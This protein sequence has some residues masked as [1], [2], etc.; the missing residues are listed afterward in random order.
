MVE[1]AAE[2]PFIIFTCLDH[3]KLTAVDCAVVSHSHARARGLKDFP[4][5]SS[6]SSSPLFPFSLAFSQLSPVFSATPIS[7]SSGKDLN[8]LF[9]S[10]VFFLYDFIYRVFF[11][12]C[13]CF[14]CSFCF[15]VF[16][17]LA[18]VEFKTLR[19]GCSTIIILLL[20]VLSI[21][22]LLFCAF[23][24]IAVFHAE[25]SSAALVSCS[26]MCVLLWKLENALFF[27]INLNSPCV[28]VLDCEE[29]HDS[30]LWISLCLSGSLCVSLST[31]S[32][33][34]SHFGCTTARFCYLLIYR[35]RI[36]VSIVIDSFRGW[37]SWSCFRKSSFLWSLLDPPPAE[38][39]ISLPSLVF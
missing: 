27:L 23:Y 29:T 33:T 31:L 15:F 3:E 24:S 9:C 21:S 4:P 20:L 37:S 8:D 1:Y 30:W 11:C 22:S 36:I 19:I 28:D 13:F 14:R 17:S 7:S 10:S 18:P 34:I 32:G 26:V 39:L 2:S 12:F 6:S 16:F 38:D 35:R 5:V 25:V